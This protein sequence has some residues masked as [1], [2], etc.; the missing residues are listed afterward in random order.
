VSTDLETRLRE[1]LHDPPIPPEVHARLRSHALEHFGRSRRRT[2]LSWM[3][4]GVRWSAGIA[5]AAAFALLIAVLI[6]ATPSDPP[7][8]ADDSTGVEYV[9]RAVPLDAGESG[10]GAAASLAGILR[11][12]AESLGI[13][14]L[15]ASAEGDR[16]TLFIPGTHRTG[17]AEM[18][19]LAN[20]NLTVY[21]N[22]SSLVAADSDLERLLP[23][24]RRAAQVRGGRAKYYAVVP[25]SDDRAS[26]PDHLEGP[27][28]SEQEAA[29]RA[30]ELGVNLGG[31]ARVVSVDA[32]IS[33]VLNYGEYVNGAGPLPILAA[34]H[35]PVARPGDIANIRANDATVVVT[36]APAA[37]DAVVDRVET[38]DPAAG[39][40]LLLVGGASTLPGLTFEGYDASRGEI[41]FRTPNAQTA[42]G[43]ADSAAGGGLDALVAVE[44]ARPVGPAPARPGEPVAALPA[45]LSPAQEN[46]GLAP[47]PGSVLRV[48]GTEHAGEEVTVYSWTGRAG[49]DGFGVTVGREGAAVSD[50]CPLSPD[51]PLLRP[52]VAGGFVGKDRGVVGRVGDE[53]EGLRAVYADGSEIDAVVGNR[54]FAMFLPPSEGAPA[55]IDALG[56]G[57]AVL[58]TF[59]PTVPGG[60]GAIF[61]PD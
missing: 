54:W 57:G 59:D 28:G 17:W 61:A 30:A 33:L 20:L 11:A 43:Y 12:K 39:E 10:R 45:G 58:E 16:V 35:D 60:E 25:Q 4:R 15:V 32:A 9:L 23:I 26:L 50:D 36:V 19:L 5:G 53:V 44:Q 34:L 22:A 31:R 41:T 37:R 49:N 1:V 46:P 13:A 27:Y 48:L 6:V 18:F 3:R 29:K 7:A 40:S 56:S 2:R 52:C 38:L 24:A 42:T 47:V 55:R 14:G 51:Q 8:E 21:D